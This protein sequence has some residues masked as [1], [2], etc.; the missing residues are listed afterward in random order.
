MNDLFTST[1]TVT[2]YRLSWKF[3]QN[4]NRS[5][6]THLWHTVTENKDT[7]GYIK[8]NR[9]HVWIDASHPAV[10]ELHWLAD[11]LANPDPHSR[12]QGHIKPSEMTIGRAAELAFQRPETL[13][14]EVTQ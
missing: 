4:A 11:Y 1:Q 6:S 3:I 2:A 13:T 9:T 10:S 7:P 5:W 12:E 8:S 14:V